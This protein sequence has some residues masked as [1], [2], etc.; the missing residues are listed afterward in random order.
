MLIKKGPRFFLG[1][2]GHKPGNNLLSHDNGVILPLAVEGLTAVFEM[3]TGVSPHL[4]SPDW[5]PMLGF[6]HRVD[7]RLV[8][9][10]SFA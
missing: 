6:G 2:V 9:Y 10:C 5:F 7:G 4:W 1:M 8:D 3:G